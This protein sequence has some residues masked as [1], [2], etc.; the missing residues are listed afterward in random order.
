MKRGILLIALMVCGGTAAMADDES[1]RPAILTESAEE[2]S[3][4]D[5]AADPASF[6]YVYNPYY[7][8][9]IG[10]GY[11]APFASLYGVSPYYTYYGGPYYAYPNYAT[12]V[13]TAYSGYGWGVA[14]PYWGVY[15]Y[16]PYFG[17]PYGGY[18]TA[19]QPY[20]IVP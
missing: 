4:K 19:F 1:I 12:Y 14:Y 8:Y 13:G 11:Y 18:A 3:S 2:A 5:V 6:V 7:S 9:F 20:L 15:P 17:W 16:Y 10:G